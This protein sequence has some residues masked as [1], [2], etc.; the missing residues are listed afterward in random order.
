MTTSLRIPVPILYTV[1]MLVQSMQAFVGIATGQIR[2]AA[3][4][5]RLEQTA[6]EKI[7]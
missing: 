7:A 4:Q 6:S 5:L 1:T 2:S 3:K